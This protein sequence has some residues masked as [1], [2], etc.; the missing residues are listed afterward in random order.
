MCSSWPGKSRIGNSSFL[1]CILTVFFYSNTQLREDLVQ[2]SNII[3]DLNSE[4]YEQQ[5][6]I[7]HLAAGEVLKFIL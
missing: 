2:M 1:P 5:L 7:E 4:I 3:D 6:E